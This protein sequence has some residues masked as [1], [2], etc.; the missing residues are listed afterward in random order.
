MKVLIV[1]TMIKML[2]I[3]EGIMFAFLIQLTISQV[4]FYQLIKLTKLKIEIVINFI[5]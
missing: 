3:K 5:F 4:Y 2:K 1:S